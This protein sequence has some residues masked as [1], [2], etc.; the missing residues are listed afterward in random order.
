[1]QSWSLHPRG[2]GCVFDAQI[3]PKMRRFAEARNDNNTLPSL[4]SCVARRPRV[5]SVHV[6][7]PSTWQ[8]PALR[9]L[10]VLVE[11]H[12]LGSQD[13]ECIR[14]VVLTFRAADESGLGELRA[15]DIAAALHSQGL[16]VPADLDA[17]CGRV[18]ISQV[19]MSRD[20]PR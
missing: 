4:S 14:K 9:R 3:I 10:A 7:L 18:D 13:D 16:E 6:S 8:A 15:A 5:T 2:G 11:A 19:H 12:L 1:M 20:G 17:I